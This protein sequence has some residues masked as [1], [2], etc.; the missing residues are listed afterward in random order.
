ML[1]DRLYDERQCFMLGKITRAEYVAIL[2]EA[3]MKVVTI[4]RYLA[5][6]AMQLPDETTFYFNSC[7][8]MINEGVD[9]SLDPS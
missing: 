6:L 8:H 5:G 2:A 3:H 7:Q 4:A 1:W 9:V